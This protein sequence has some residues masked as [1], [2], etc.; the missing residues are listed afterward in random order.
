MRVIDLSH[1]IS[2]KMTH[3]PGTQ[4]TELKRE[5]TFEKDGFRVSRI[6]MSSHAGTHL[7]SPS[8]MFGHGYYLNDFPADKFVG[9]GL[10]LNFRNLQDSTID[11]QD[12][13]PFAPQIRK[14]DFLLLNSGQS[15]LWGHDSY[16]D[17]YPVLSDKAARWL[18]GF[19]L[20]GVGIDMISFDPVDS[21]DCL[22]HKILLGQNLVL[23]EN[24]N[25]LEVLEEKEFI[26]IC[27]P[28]KLEQADG[29]PVRAAALLEIDND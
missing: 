12:L 21:R 19:T 26:F 28:L 7:D 27:L 29:S 9:K 20:K 18:A 13:L 5:N 6:I 15:K 10:C 17:E 16:F 8:H 14:V 3:F 1:V 22:V 2:S 11:V 4:I 25:Q 23:I 24:L